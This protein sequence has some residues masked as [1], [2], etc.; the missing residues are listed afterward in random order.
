MHILNDCIQKATIPNTLQYTHHTPHTTNYTP[1]IPHKL[2]NIGIL[3]TL[4]RILYT[5]W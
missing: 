4:P 1:Y 3:Y 2:P 5:F